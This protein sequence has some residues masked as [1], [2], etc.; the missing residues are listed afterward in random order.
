MAGVDFD[1]A[2]TAKTRGPAGTPFSLG[3]RMQDADG[4][5]FVYVQADGAITAGD[6][7]ILTDGFQADQLDTTSSAGA[8]GDKVGVAKGT[9][10]DD[11]YGWVQ[12]YG[13][14]SAVNAATGCA[15]N[16]TLNSTGTA[17]RVD[18]DEAGGAESI[19]GLYITATAADN[20]APGIVN[21]PFIAATL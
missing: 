17:G 21:Y 20:T 12:V 6:V 3:Q 16:A 8:I 13:V 19:T 10:A 9:L 1:G 2:Y 11:D 15:A 18:D 5:E 7:V 14:A 4:N